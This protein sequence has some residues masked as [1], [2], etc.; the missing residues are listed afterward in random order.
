M[1]GNKSN[2]RIQ[3]KARLI[4]IGILLVLGTAY[5]AANWQQAQASFSWM[6]QAET[7]YP[8]IVG[9]PL[10]DC[11]LCHTSGSSLN[12][13]GNAFGRNNHSFTAIQNLDSDGDSFTNLAEINAH[14]FPGD[15]NSHPVIVPTTT[16][17]PPTATR[18][19]THTPVPPTATRTQVPPTATPLPPTATRTAVPATA[20]STATRVPPTATSANTSVPPTATM[21]RAVPTA[22][23]TSIAATP[24][25]SSTTV[26]A[27][28]TPR[29]TPTAT[30]PIVFRDVIRQLPGTPS[31]IGDWRIGSRTVHV[32]AQTRLTTGNDRNDEENDGERVSVGMPAIVKGNVLADGSVNATSVQV[33]DDDIGRQLQRWIREFGER[34]RRLK[35]D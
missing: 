31:L 28:K 12:S 22:T 10:D 17:V 29:K 6:M 18:T 7:A 19:A 21:T 16:P 8:T 11:A 27:T 2:E 14:T 23:S 26:S 1:H 33:Q 4:G 34:L 25:R 15:P 35:G 24:T 9:T 30:H 3:W 32:T 20:T 13:Y 5:A